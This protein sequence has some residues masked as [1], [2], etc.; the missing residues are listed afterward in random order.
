[1]LVQSTKSDPVKESVSSLLSK[2]PRRSSSSKGVDS[3]LP[4]MS[5]VYETTWSVVSI[6][7]TKVIVRW[8]EGIRA[9][10]KMKSTKPVAAQ[11]GCY[12]DGSEERSLMGVWGSKLPTRASSSRRRNAKSKTS[13]VLSAYSLETN[14]AE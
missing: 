12:C 7:L 1:M 9:N 14:G 13:C 10:A 6:V 8:L 3:S 11:V 4:D 2:S 5:S